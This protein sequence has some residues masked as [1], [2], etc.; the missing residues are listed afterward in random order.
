MASSQNI[1]GPK[2]LSPLNTDE[3]GS[4]VYKLTTPAELTALSLG[5]NLTFDTGRNQYTECLYSVDDGKTWTSAFRRDG[6]TNRDNYQFEIDKRIPLDNPAGA[7]EALVKV[8]MKKNANNKIFGINQ[9]RLYAFY[10]QPQA[11]GARLSVEIAW[12]EKTG[13]KWE[14]KRKSLVVDKFPTDFE[15]DC[16]G[17][18]ARLSRLVMAP[19]P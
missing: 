13:D 8:V 17:E 1:A 14:D 7:R 10:R 18:A 5:A 12:Q 11:A 16:G 2:N 6:N 9:L 4:A 19:A 3:P 15:L